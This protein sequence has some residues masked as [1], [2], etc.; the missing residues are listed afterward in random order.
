MHCPFCG[1]EDTQVKDSRPAEDGHS[2]RRRRQCPS[3]GGRFTT[4][5][6]VQIRELKV[7]KRDGTREHFDRDKLHRSVSIALRKRDVPEE[8]VEQLVSDIVRQLEKSG[9][10]EISTSVLGEHVMKALADTDPVAYVRYASVYRDFDKAEDFGRFVDEEL[11]AL[12]GRL[13]RRT[14]PRGA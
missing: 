14:P 7:M 5:E 2:I 11:G 4:Y 10:S 13:S 9:E 8:R 1:Y 3:C 12:K 6:R